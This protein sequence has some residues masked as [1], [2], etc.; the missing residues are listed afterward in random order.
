MSSP[1]AGARLAEIGYQAPPGIQLTLNGRRY[2]CQ[3]WLRIVPGRR[4]VADCGRGVI[5]KLFVGRGAARRSLREY[6]QLSAL[7]RSG[8]AVPRV[9]DH[10]QVQPGAWAVLMEQVVAD[11]R[12]DAEQLVT[13]LAALHDAGFVHRDPH[14]GNFL[15]SNGRCVLIDAGAIRAAPGAV[16]A[17]AAGCVEN[18][19][20]LLADLDVVDAAALRRLWDVYRRARRNDAAGLARLARSVDGNRRLLADARVRKSERDGS[21]FCCVAVPGYRGHRL[22]QT[23]LGELLEDP[24]RTFRGGRLAKAGHTASV[25]RV[26]VDGR[27]YAMK[28]YRIKS[29]WHRLRQSL[30]TSRA[31]RSWRAAQRLLQVGVSVPRAVL[32]L[33]ARGLLAGTNWLVS[34]WHDGETLEVAVSTMDDG[35]LGACAIQL[36]EIWR[37]LAVL[38]L[39]HGDAKASNYLW[40]G[41]RLWMLDLDS[42]GASRS[43]WGGDRARLLRSLAG[44]PRAVEVFE[45]A[46]AGPR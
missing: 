26:E 17:G 16:R 42:V 4:L 2:I 18:L 7:R 23:S 24:E 22:R 20:R 45:R 1:A 35:T 28:R 46:L 12:P 14:P 19:G 44:H 34:D 40:D 27:A 31:R 39:S 6:R 21:E 10:G 43:G 8:C 36:A 37:R 30:R 32:L 25:A 11:G 15:V 38:G 33:E 29:P 13:A 41:A 5:A 9:I 3:R